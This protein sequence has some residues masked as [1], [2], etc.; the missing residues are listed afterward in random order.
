MLI[1]MCE[2]IMPTSAADVVVAVVDLTVA[3]AVGGVL[4]NCRSAAACVSA[5][6]LVSD[7]V[8]TAEMRAGTVHQTT[9]AVGVAVHKGLDSTAADAGIPVVDNSVAAS[10]IR[11]VGT[12]THA[13]VPRRGKNH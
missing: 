2:V 12:P 10:R 13:V 9:T 3:A 6:G 1:R 7:D 5:M 11:A 8:V 4:V